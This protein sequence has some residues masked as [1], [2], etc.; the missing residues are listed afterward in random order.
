MSFTDGKFVLTNHISQN[1][2]SAEN[3]PEW[4]W[5]LK[6]TREISINIS[7]RTGPTG[8]GYAQ[9]LNR[10][11]GSHEATCSYIREKHGMDLWA[12]GLVDSKFKNLKLIN[13]S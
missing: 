7:L 3:F 8:L 5:D 12:H 13:N 1:F 9:H 6:F 2:L 11:R 10:S 4:K